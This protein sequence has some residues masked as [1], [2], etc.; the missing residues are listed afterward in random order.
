MDQGALCYSSAAL[1]TLV[2]AQPGKHDW[3]GGLDYGYQSLSVICSLEPY[4]MRRATGAYFY[5]ATLH[6]GF[7]EQSNYSCRLH[8]LHPFDRHTVLWRHDAG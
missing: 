8:R 5:Q 1:P 6:L 7:K 4:A 2:Q 3:G